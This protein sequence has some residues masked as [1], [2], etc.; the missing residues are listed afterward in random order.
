[1]KCPLT[2]LNWTV[3]TI[4]F[5]PLRMIVTLCPKEPSRWLTSMRCAGIQLSV[6]SMSKML[7]LLKDTSILEMCKTQSS[8]KACLMMRHASIATSLMR[9]LMPNARMFGLLLSQVLVAIWLSW[10][11]KNGP[12]TQASTALTGIVTWKCMLVMA[13]KTVTSISWI[14]NI[15]IKW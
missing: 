14:E 10:E 15:N 2:S 4:L 9:L 1:M 8:W 13:W 7:C 3:Y 11:I 5:A 12:A 6:A